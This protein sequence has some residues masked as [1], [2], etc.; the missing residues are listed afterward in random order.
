MK[1]KNVRDLV[2]DKF[3]SP[4]TKDLTNKEN[5]FKLEED[6]DNYYINAYLENN[7]YHLA[8]L[9]KDAMN[10]LYEEYKKGNN[11]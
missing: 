3:L 5:I 1:Y 8:T 6:D 9:Y 7:K 10:E 4:F 2:E 11:V